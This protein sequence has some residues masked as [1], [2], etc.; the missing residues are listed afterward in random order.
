MVGVVID[1]YTLG[2][3]DDS[4]EAAVYPTE[5]GYACL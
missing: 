3:I 4:V 1:K 5:R 2:G